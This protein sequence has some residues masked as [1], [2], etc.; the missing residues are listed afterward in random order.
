MN[1]SKN[2]LYKE[3]DKKIQNAF[4][5]LLEFNDMDHICIN[6]ICTA[7]HISRPTFY[8]HYDDIN[9]LIMKIEYEKSLYIQT[10]LTAPKALSQDDFIK[11][12]IYIKENK[13]F[14]IAYF[15]C[16]TSSNLSHS[17]MDQYLSA[18]GKKNTPAMKYQMLFFMAGLK[19]VVFDWLSQNCPESIERLSKVL[20]NHY[21]LFK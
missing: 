20:L 16:E 7:A 19:A 8:A 4:L 10:L 14:Y 9:D 17:M 1:I 12:L 6:S 2:S 13:N 15:R 11:Y 3:T 21:L 5:S 18:N